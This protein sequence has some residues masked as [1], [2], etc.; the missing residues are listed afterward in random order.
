MTDRANYQYETRHESSLLTP[1][2][3]TALFEKGFL[4]NG[5][6]LSNAIPDNIKQIPTIEKFKNRLRGFLLST[7]VYIIDE[8][9]NK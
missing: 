9:L 6:K 7:V 4:Y 2:H 5:F 8:F 1:K 3:N